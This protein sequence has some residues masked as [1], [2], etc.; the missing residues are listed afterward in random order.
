[1]TIK[2]IAQKTGVSVATVSNII[3]NKGRV[4]DETRKRVEACIREAKYM[5]NAMAQNLKM[6]RSRT[7][8]VIAEDMTVFVQPDIID[9]ITEHCEEM[10]YQ[11]LLVNLRLYKKYNDTYYLSDEHK[12]LSD[13]AIQKL[14]ALQVEGII[15]I[16]AHERVNDIIPEDIP[17]PVVVAYSFGN[18][19]RFPSVVVDDRNGARILME[20]LIGKGHSKIGVIA[21]K[22][23]SFHTRKRIEGYQ[24]TLFDHG[25]VVNPDYV[26][27]GDWERE[28]GYNHTEELVKKG[29][30]AIFCMN[31]IMAGGAYDKL[32]EMGLKVGK[33]I[34]VVGYDNQIMASYEK[35][36]L[37]TV[38]LPLHDIGY[39]A[40]D[41]ILKMLS[42]EHF[43]NT[44]TV[45]YVECSLC[46]R[47][48]VKDIS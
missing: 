2:E 45:Y 40:C 47:D 30:T 24:S 23:E 43:K 38:G 12:E 19:P 7:I 9:G 27:Y 15:Y 35:P 41:V 14:L 10:G 20:Y 34:S 36:P 16:A 11:V 21:G 5:P 8:G 46:E 25:I 37:T 44:E 18:N 6:Q 48:S 1:M 28:S 13:N 31:D 22:K 4:S 42:G 26:V 17:V 39:T 32:E 3:N 33:D 29:V